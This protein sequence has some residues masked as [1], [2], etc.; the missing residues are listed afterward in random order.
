MS[1]Y[2]QCNLISEQLCEY[3][4]RKGEL[5][6][7]PFVPNKM[8]KDVTSWMALVNNNGTAGTMDSCV[9]VKC[10]YSAKC[11]TL[12]FIFQEPTVI[13]NQATAPYYATN[14][15]KFAG[16]AN[17]MD[18]GNWCVIHSSRRL[19]RR[20]TS[21]HIQADS[22]ASWLSYP[23]SSNTEPFTA[24]FDSGPLL[25][26]NAHPS[27]PRI[28][29]WDCGRK[30]CTTLDC[31]CESPVALEKL[32]NIWLSLLSTTSLPPLTQA[33][34]VAISCSVNLRTT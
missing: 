5:K 32:I 33:A 10:N 17:G 22:N 12:I 13:E 34:P 2:S 27:I 1:V 16:G 26:C 30:S 9:R 21:L 14:Y 23:N 7:P 3:C 6:C 15:D 25:V 28:G 11:D 8:R 18:M 19:E 31:F 24:I 4:A 20:L 29:F